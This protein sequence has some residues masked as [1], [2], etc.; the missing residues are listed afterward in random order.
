MTHVS[1]FAGIDGIGI[2]AEWAGFRTIAQVESDPFC[3]Q[4]LEKHWPGV[5]RCDDI[6]QFPGNLA[7]LTGLGPVTLISAGP[8]CQPSS[9]AGER[10]GRKD[11][12][13]LW[14]EVARVVEELLPRWVLAENPL[15]IL[16]IEN[17]VAIEEWLARLET[18][19]YEI[20]PPVVYPIAALGAD[21]R[22]YRVF[23][24]AHLDG[25]RRGPAEIPIEG[26]S[27]TA[28][29]GNDRQDVADPDSS[30]REG[31]QGEP[32]PSGS[33]RCGVAY[34]CRWWDTRSWLLRMVSGVRGRMDGRR[35]RALGNSCSPYQ[36][37]PVLQAIAE[38]ERE[39]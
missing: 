11:D 20:L 7:V 37:A 25:K 16:S 15:G 17:G 10:R 29:V 22:R 13:W 35:I 19:N 36:V 30:R 32:T 31:F 12:R 9:T 14:P 8:P 39:S 28:I 21:H 38:V 5:F 26:G 24:V 3:L 33:H 27:D 18:A 4:V 6:R 34:P 23:F 1:L 2:A